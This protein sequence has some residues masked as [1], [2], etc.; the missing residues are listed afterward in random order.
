MLF[1]SLL[2]GFLRRSTTLVVDLPA[3]KHSEQLISLVLI[4]SSLY[5]YSTASYSVI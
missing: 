5:P 3:S 2:R 4:F 1:K